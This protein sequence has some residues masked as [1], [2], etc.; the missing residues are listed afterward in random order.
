M[1]ADIYLFFRSQLGERFTEH[2]DAPDLM[3]FRLVD[4]FTSA[5]DPAHKD[6][7]IQAFTKESHLRI[8]IATIAF[9]MR[10]NCP[11]I[12][13]VVHVDMPDDIES[14]IQ[15]TGRDGQPSLAVLLRTEAE[16][17]L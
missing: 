15:H 3:E 16:G 8:I 12:R 13:Q 5:T 14:Y 1:C 2:T 11:N 9:G 17:D 6:Y 10:L 4:M 7:I